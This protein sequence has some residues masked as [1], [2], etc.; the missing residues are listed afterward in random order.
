MNQPETTP[1]DPYITKRAEAAAL[2]T[3][4]TPS[5]FD[6]LKQFKELDR[7]VLRFFCVWDDRDAM[8]GEMRSF[9]IHVSRIGP[10]E[11]FRF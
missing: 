9:I 8:F 4:D 10:V 3:Y 7:K 6:K 5:S 2:R 1:L 11:R